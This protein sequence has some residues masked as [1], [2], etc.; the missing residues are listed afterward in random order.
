MT[1]PT[2]QVAEIFRSIQ[3]ESTRAGLPCAF[4][5]LTGCGLRCVWCDSAYAFHGGSAMTVGDA[6]GRVLALGTDLVEVTGGEP[7]EQEGVYPLMTRLLDAGRT[8]LLETGGHVPLDRVDPR[9]VKI[10][11][12][13]A[14]G[15]GMAQA[16]LPENLSGLQP[17]DELKF[18]LADRRDFDWALSL[19]REK[20]L[21]SERVVTFSPVWESLPAGELA[22]WV[23]DCGRPIR[24]GLQLHKV[25][26][27]DVPGR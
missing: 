14:P 24:L 19:V 25:L 22:E 26:W 1:E 15:S 13:K 7:L 18:V 12:V 27:G 3:G 23:R 10:V 6:A 11:D 9:V 2:L 8:V 20:A 17:H 16:N 5:R 21:D 4:I